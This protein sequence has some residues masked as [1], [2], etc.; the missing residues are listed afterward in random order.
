MFDSLELDYL[1]MSDSKIKNSFYETTVDK[2][3][4]VIEI[5]IMIRDALSNP[6]KPS[7][8]QEENS[9]FSTKNT[10]PTTYFKRY[11]RRYICIK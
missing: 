1:P 9:V 2:G 6:F 5:A 4:T 3:I 8:K 10:T 7:G 11:I